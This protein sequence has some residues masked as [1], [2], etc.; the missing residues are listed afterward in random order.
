VNQNISNRNGIGLGSK[1]NEL[2]K[3]FDESVW[4]VVTN[5]K[6]GKV[7]SYGDVARLAGFPKR[8]RMVARA[9]GKSPQRLPWHRVVKSDLTIA[10]KPGSEPFLKQKKLLQ[11][12]GVTFLKGKVIPKIS[13]KGRDLD[14]ILWGPE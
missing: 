12:E 1:M 9:M 3:N 14:D 6:V 7:L 2:K 8:A 11:D 4:D 5:I 10:F 13:D